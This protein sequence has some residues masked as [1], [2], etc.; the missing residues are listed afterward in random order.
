MDARFTAEQE[1]IRRTV[2]ELLLKRCGPEEVRAAVRTR[3]G[4]DGGLWAALSDQ[5]GLP[6]LALPETYGG[7]GCSVTELALAVEELG[8]SLTP[9]PLL[10]SSVLVAPL[11]LALGAERQ[12]AELLPPLASGRLTAALAVPGGALSTALALTAD[13]RGAWSG[14]GRAGGVQARRAGDGWRLY[15]EAGQVLDGH[16]AGLLVVAAHAGGYARSRTLL[17]LVRAGEGEDGDGGGGGAA[18]GVERVRQTSLDETRPV[19]RLELR[20]VRAE[21]LGDDDTADVPGA[22]ARVGD[23]AAAVLAAEAVGVA[24]RA[25]ERT[26]AYVRQREQ[27]GRPIGSFQAVKHR[28]ADVYVGVRAARSA[29][30]YAAWAAAADS[31]GAGG[32]GRRGGERVGGLA[33]AQAL[34]ALRVAAG[35]GI[36][37]HGGIGFTWEHEAQS[38]FKRAAGDELL[39]GPVHRLRGRAAD[40][41]GVFTGEG[42]QHEGRERDGRGGGGRAP[43]GRELDG[44]GVHE[45][46]RG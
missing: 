12:R 41:A 7:V 23:A 18:S 8:R 28:L 5:L 27:F 13:N 14:G 1:E 44:R 3:E 30:Y 15:G 9:S 36:Q 4:Y 10:S 19:A 33:L 6:G 29:A 35:E 31:P 37:L 38:Y 34:E 17:F 25:L 24:D 2:R 46:V 32:R 11:I 40:A 39:F 20:D 26:V 43:G 21:L 16:S 45:E 22:L 42:G